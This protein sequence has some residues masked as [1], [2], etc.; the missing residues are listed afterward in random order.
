MYVQTY[1]HVH[2]PGH[3][4]KR[5]SDLSELY[6]CGMPW[7]GLLNGF[8]DSDS[9][10][11]D[12]MATALDCLAV[13]PVFLTRLLKQ[14]LGWSGRRCVADDDPPSAYDPPASPPR[15]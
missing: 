6:S 3:A 7:P 2:V 1:V 11:Y 10:P 13:S 8:W 12:E 9:N 15:G 14:G 5:A 4:Q